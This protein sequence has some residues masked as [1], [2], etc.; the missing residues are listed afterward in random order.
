MLQIAMLAEALAL[1]GSTT[2]YSVCQIDQVNLTK[3]SPCTLDTNT[4]PLFI[5]IG[6]SKIKN[7]PGSLPDLGSKF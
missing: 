7:E 6:K 3:D 5:G 1:A 4:F 2:L